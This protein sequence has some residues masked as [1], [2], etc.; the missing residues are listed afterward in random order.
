MPAS[1]DLKEQW[2][3]GIIHHTWQPFVS[4]Q[5]SLFLE[6]SLNAEINENS[7]IFLKSG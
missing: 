6:V 4:N 3:E 7:D 1:F 5:V 2:K